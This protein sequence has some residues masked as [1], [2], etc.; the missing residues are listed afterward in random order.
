MAVEIMI[1]LKEKFNLCI[2]SCLVILALL[3]F[4]S[5]SNVLK[6]LLGK[7]GNITSVKTRHCIL[8]REQFSASHY[9]SQLDV[10]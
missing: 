8:C 10:P 9:V 2:Y 7:E 1:F 5:T 4:E 6:E 3:H